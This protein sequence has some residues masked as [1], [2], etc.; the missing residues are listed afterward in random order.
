MLRLLGALLITV[1]IGIVIGMGV[2]AMG[3]KMVLVPILMGLLFSA[4]II[5]GLELLSL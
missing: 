5:L 2:K 4:S 1:P 3:A